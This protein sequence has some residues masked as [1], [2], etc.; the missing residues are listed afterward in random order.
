MTQFL[1]SLRHRLSHIHQSLHI[2]S[3][4]TK[5]AESEL[6]QISNLGSPISL[7]WITIPTDPHFPHLVQI[8]GEQGLDESWC[9]EQLQS[10]SAATVA[11]IDQDGQTIP[12]GVGMFTRNEFFVGEID[13][14]YQPG[15]AAA[16]LYATYVSPPFR[17]QRI[18]RLLDLHRVHQAAQANAPYAIAI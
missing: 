12:A 9:L 15:P 14:L 16:Y 3:R 1:R 8:Q 10:G 6:F 13:S 11:T 5:L 18:Q 17:G 4:P 7:H 2:L